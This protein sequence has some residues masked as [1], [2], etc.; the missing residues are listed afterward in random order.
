M[1]RY[2]PFVCTILDKLRGFLYTATGPNRFW[3]QVKITFVGLT[4]LGICGSAHATFFNSAAFANNGATQSS[5]YTAAGIS[6]PQ[7]LVDFEAIPVST[8]VHGNASLFPNLT[9]TTSNSSAVVT[10]GAGSIGGSN[11]IGARALQ[12]AEGNNVFLTFATPVDYIGG[13]DIDQ[14]GLSLTVFLVGGGSESVNLETTAGDGNSAEFWGYVKN[15]GGPQISSVRFSGV[16]GASGWA[17]DNLQYN[18][19]VP[20]PCTI[21]ALGTGAVALMRRRMAK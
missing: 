8:N 11:P 6:S 10:S 14:S 15:S 13:F 17:L 2:M 16:S 9:I 20:E 12:M 18:T 7:W 19:P 21:L 5:F 3:I 1:L 4:L